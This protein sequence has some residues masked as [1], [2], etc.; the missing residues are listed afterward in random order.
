M[1]VYY[2]ILL[3]IIILRTG[4]GCVWSIHSLYRICKGLVKGYLGNSILF[5]LWLV[6]CVCSSICVPQD[7]LY[8]SAASV[9]DL[10]SLCHTPTSRALFDYLQASREWMLGYK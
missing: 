5:Y 4:D 3:Y 6:C 8:S 2:Y 7:S 1:A 10:E 9:V